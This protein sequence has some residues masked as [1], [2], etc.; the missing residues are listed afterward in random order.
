MTARMMVIALFFV[1]GLLRCGGAVAGPLDVFLAD[2]EKA[3]ATAPPARADLSAERKEGE[4]VTRYEAVAIHQ[5][6]DVYLEIRD[7]Q[8]RVLVQ[9]ERVYQVL[10]ADGGK[11]STIGP[12]APIDGTP[13]IA[14]DVRPFRA[15]VLQL[16][17]ITDETSKMM[18]VSGAPTEESP[19]VLI[20]YLFDRQKKLASRAQYYERVINN[21]VRM[22]RESELSQVGGVWRPGRTEIEDYTVGAVTTIETKW[23]ANPEIPDGLFDPA[24]LGTLSLLRGAP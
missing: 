1:G 11:P 15:A 18:L 17:Q 7:P 5:G 21:M 14:D 16:P 22:R 10:G 8:V 4:T 23:T 9:G 13:F 3:Q 6:P 19:Y 24:K 2:I 20:V 12:H